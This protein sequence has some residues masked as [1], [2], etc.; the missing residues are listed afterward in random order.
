MTV[1]GDSTNYSVFR[2]M[3]D[4]GVENVIENEPVG[5]LRRTAA[6]NLLEVQ[7]LR[8]HSRLVKSEILRVG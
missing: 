6:G 5:S 7:A 3:S 1:S 8:S 2:S 4:L